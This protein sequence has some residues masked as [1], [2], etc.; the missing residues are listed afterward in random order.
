NY[1]KVLIPVAEAY[2]Q[3]PL[4]QHDRTAAGKSWHNP[5]AAGQQKF[6]PVYIDHEESTSSP[7]LIF[8]KVK[9][10]TEINAHELMHVF[11]NFNSTW[12]EEGNAD[13][14]GL[15]M[16]ILIKVQNPDVFWEMIGRNPL[17][18]MDPATKASEA[19]DA[20]VASLKQKGH[21][22]YIIQQLEQEEK[23]KENN[24]TKTMSEVHAT[25][26]NAGQIF[27]YDLEHLIGEQAMQAGY[28]DIA[29]HNWTT[30]KSVYQA[31]RNHTPSDKV[32]DYDT[33][34][35]NKVLGTER[36]KQM[37]QKQE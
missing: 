4:S 10:G 34:W 26:T 37:L 36:F 25:L 17:N 24:K 33:L 14:L 1:Y 16:S 32:Q 11:T 2:F 6:F 19:Y 27:L 31:F 20:A 23:E 28:R 15:K 5:K 7:R 21:G 9:R 35:E 22:Q 18:D 12:M 13:Y 8:T 29:K 30:N 3:S